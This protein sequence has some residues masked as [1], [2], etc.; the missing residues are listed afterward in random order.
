MPSC[1]GLFFVANPGHLE[2]YGVAF[3]AAVPDPAPTADATREWVALDDL[4]SRPDLSPVERELIP[5]VL[6]ADHPISIVL[7]PDPDS[8]PA[9]MRIVAT[10]TIDG[11]T[12][13]PLV[14]GELPG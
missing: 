6:M 7:T 12:L 3:I 13:G 10:L 1:A 14:F 2:D 11:A 9:R 4:A 8:D 5:T